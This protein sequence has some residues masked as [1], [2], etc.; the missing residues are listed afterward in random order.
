[1]GV[2]KTFCNIFVL[3]SFWRNSLYKKHLVKK[4]FEINPTLYGLLKDASDVRTAR[5]YV[6]VYLDE[7]RRLLNRES[8]GNQPLEWEIQ[9][10]SLKAFRKM[11]SVRSER[12]AKF[13]VLKVLW[14]LAHE[15]FDALSEDLNDGFFNEMIHLFLGIH[16]R[17]G[18]YNEVTRPDF[19][20]KEGREAARL[21]SKQ[22]DQIA[23]QSLKQADRYRSGLYEKSIRLREA[24]R[25]RILQHFNASAKDWLDYKWQIKHVIRDSQTLGSLI[26]L[27]SAEIEA[28]DKARAN[29]LPFGIT[30]YYVSLMDRESHRKHDHAVRAQVIPPLDYVE[31]MAAYRDDHDHSFDF[32]LEHDTSPIDLIT[33]RYPMIVILKPYNTCSQICVYCQRNWEI[34][35]CLAKGALAPKQRIEAAIQWIKDHPAI[36]EVLVTGGDPLVMQDR[37]IDDIL[38]KLA[39]IEHV[40][41][42]R[43]GSRTPVVL[44]MRIT[45]SLI[46]IISKYH[47]PG[48]REIA[49]STHFEHPYEITPESMQAVQAFKK[50]GMSVYNQAVF[51][52]ENSRRNE[53]VA[54]RHFL[55]KIGV[56][57]YYTFN[58]KGKEETR[59]YRV[60]L[61]RLQQEIKEEARLMPG[62]ERTDEAVYNVPG[63]GKNYL[64][65]QQHHSLLSILPNGR[66]VYEFHPWEKNLSIANT[67]VDVDVSITEYLKE[68]KRRGENPEDY[69]S[70]WY[71]F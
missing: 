28:I 4:L 11:V 19:I 57:P 70:I 1:M 64:R 40:E 7:T 30:P 25:K 32:M 61:A 42:I 5:N 3:F 65:A 34:E 56:D 10:R 6:I 49:I 12:L 66:R 54:L 47:E 52:V 9:M 21:R 36:R 31:Q 29:H 33:R 58:T 22:L 63:L 18:I 51:T 48:L 46:Q 2:F 26:R 69:Q 67:F 8:F 20:K 60:P 14:H 39:D 71:Y 45:D 27:T 43:I 50:Q 41:R 62:L 15:E 53:M 16:G 23:E 37:Q 24:N 68:L 59:S 38:Q 13:S 35:D 17:S 44:P 55:R